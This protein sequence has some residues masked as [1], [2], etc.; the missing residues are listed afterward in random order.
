VLRDKAKCNRRLQIKPRRN[1]DPFLGFALKEK[2]K[3]KKMDTCPKNMR[4]SKKARVVPIIP[5]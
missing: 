3:E 2:E 4:E 1:A 5:Y